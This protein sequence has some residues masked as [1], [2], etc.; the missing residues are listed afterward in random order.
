MSRASIRRGLEFRRSPDRKLRR[1]FVARRIVADIKIM[2]A[3]P[4]DAPA[5]RN[6][7]LGTTAALG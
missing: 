2:A 3:L 6:I 5:R 1:Q 4:A 7:P